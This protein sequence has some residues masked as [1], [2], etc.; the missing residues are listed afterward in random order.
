MQ[1]KVQSNTR[2]LRRIT[3]VAVVAATVTA[4]SVPTAASAAAPYPSDSTPPDLVPLLSGFSDFWQS[5]GLKDLHGTVVDPA[6]LA[7][8]D[9]LVTWINNNATPEQQ[10]KALQDSEY[11]Q[12][13]LTYDQSVTIATGLGSV[14]GP[15]YSEGRQNG[16]LPL[17]DALINS[18][19]GTSGAYV[20]PDPAKQAYSYPRPYISSDA[21]AAPIPGDD[22]ECDPAVTNAS[23]LQANR[24]GKPYANAVGTL[25]IV[26][27]P[28]VV[29]TT[30][31]Y[32]PNDVALS[33]GYADAGIC[34]AG[35]F[36]SGHTTTAYQ[37]GITLATLLPELAPEILSRASE[38]GNNR[39]VIGVHS[40]L[41][42]V[43]GRINGEAALAARWSDAQYRTEVLEPARSELIGY[44]EQ[45]CGATLVVCIAAGT[46]YQADPYGGAAMPG[47]TAQVVT[48]RASAVAVYDERL[49]YAFPQVGTPGL[50]PAVPAGA[51]NLLLTTFPTL[52]DAQRTAVLAQTQI[53]SGY[54][55]D[56]SASGEG[57]WQRLDLAA[58]MSATVQLGADGS[59]T[60][61]AVGGDATVLA[62][63]APAPVPVPAPAP[64][65]APVP[66]AAPA[67]AATG[68]SPGDVAPWGLGALISGGVLLLAAGLAGARR[69]AIR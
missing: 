44:L 68:A 41:D 52:T 16:S 51:E 12:D 33:G 10:F 56:R 24:I 57:S 34:T 21:D 14:L 13:G 58:A 22:P 67:L 3:L 4:L 7:R 65:P 59:A 50:A 30:H 54:P 46:P 45:Q 35:A 27:I 55:L 9:E 40:P 36:P 39:L 25:E 23:S 8:N 1:S 6:V 69:R 61:V 38:N 63:P 60:V 20:S 32:S 48:D 26:R 5:D 31:A 62:A 49:T 19:D 29:D 64:A 15:L 43:G 53:D 42:I 28:D 17:M 18:E 2:R 47:G 11:Q 66:A 37:A